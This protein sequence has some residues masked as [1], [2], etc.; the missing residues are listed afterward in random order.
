MNK[1]FTNDKHPMKV[2]LI[3]VCYFIEEILS[4]YH[5]SI[6]GLKKSEFRIIFQFAR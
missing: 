6:K 4:F 2:Y 1:Y 5:Y 3:L